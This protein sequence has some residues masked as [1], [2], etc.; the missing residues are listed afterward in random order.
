LLGHMAA[1]PAPQLEANPLFMPPPT[2]Q[3][4]CIPVGLLPKPVV[5]LPVGAAGQVRKDEML[6]A[7]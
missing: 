6:E 3:L 1:R 2:M 5:F 4:V 7:G